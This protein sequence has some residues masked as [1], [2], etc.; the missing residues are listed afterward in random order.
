[1][2]APSAG[3]DD[4]GAGACAGDGDRTGDQPPVQAPAQRQASLTAVDREA[5]SGVVRG[6]DRE[7]KREVPWQRSS[8]AMVFR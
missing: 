5:L 2:A 8:S 6:D 7:V 4:V 3:A 1:V